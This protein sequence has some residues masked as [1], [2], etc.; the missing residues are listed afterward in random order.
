MIIKDIEDL[1]IKA[2]NPD[3]LTFEE[4]E[5]LMPNE[6]GGSQV[7]TR[8][9]DEYYARNELKKRYEDRIGKLFDADSETWFIFDVA[10]NER[11]NKIKNYENKHPYI[12][13]RCRTGN[14]NIKEFHIDDAEYYLHKEELSCE[15]FD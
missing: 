12:V 7:T 15:L 5:L 6:R 13:Y 1:I 2:K 10:Y 14:S 9:W 11:W 4:L 8:Y 3:A